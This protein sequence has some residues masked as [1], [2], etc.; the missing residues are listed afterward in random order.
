MNNKNKMITFSLLLFFLIPRMSYADPA[1]IL[2]F[3]EHEQGSDE[4]LIIMT[5]TDK[6]LRI[7]DSLLK[8]TRQDAEENKGF[9]LF[10]RKNKDIYSVSSE[11]QQIIKIKQVP[12]TI[13]SPI[14]LKL[15]KLSL[16]VDNKAPLINGK[17]TQHHQIFVNDKLCTN[18]IT[19]PELMPDA[20]IALKNFN[21]VLA[22]QQAESLRYIPGDLHEACDLARHS[23][24]PQSHLENG[25]PMMIQT[26]GKSGKIE[27]LKSTRILID[28]KQKNVVDDY[29]ALPDYDVVKIN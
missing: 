14:E 18:M 16:D 6:Y 7:D 19:V 8:K 29:F 9:V 27:D 5:I 26:I 20:V 2:Y 11:E 1:T 10:D 12:V 3:S 28:F 24:Y 25:F 23:F 17:K 22:G 21:Q 13:P 4:V 15:N